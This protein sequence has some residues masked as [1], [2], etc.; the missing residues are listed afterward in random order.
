MKGLIPLAIT[1]FLV[2]VVYRFLSRSKS[3]RVTTGHTNSKTFNPNVATEPKR[4]R[5]L[6]AGDDYAIELD[7]PKNSFAKSQSSVA[8]DI[9]KHLRNIDKFQFEK[10]VEI[11]YRK[12][13]Y[14]VKRPSAT[15]PKRGIDLVIE[16]DGEPSAVQ[17]KHWQNLNLSVGTVS[18]F[19][20]AITGAGIQKGIFVS[21][22]SFTT[23]AKQLGDKHGIKI[24]TEWVLVQMLDSTDARFDLE[25]RQLLCDG[26]KLSTTRK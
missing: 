20:G 11:T 8:V 16:K 1:L 15:D 21:L 9:S 3:A 17:C 2:F 19:V 4:S 12:L 25:V 14:K 10:L 26:R 13:G 5:P 22:N 24:V 6:G 7:T 23:E 18:E